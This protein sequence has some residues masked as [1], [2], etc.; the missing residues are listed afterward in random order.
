VFATSY[1]G[2]ANNPLTAP[3]TNHLKQYNAAGAATAFNAMVAA[4]KLSSR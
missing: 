1:A 3:D 4:D 2:F